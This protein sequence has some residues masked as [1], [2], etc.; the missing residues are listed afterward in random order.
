MRQHRHRTAHAISL[1][2][3][4]GETAWREQTINFAQTPRHHR[5]VTPELRRPPI[6]QRAK[7]AL[8][9]DTR[10]LIEFEQNVSGTDEPVF[11]RGVELNRAAKPQH[12]GAAHK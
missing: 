9:L 11:V 12:T 7:K 1:Q 10:D 3:F 5:R 6:L 8:L 4:L 2:P